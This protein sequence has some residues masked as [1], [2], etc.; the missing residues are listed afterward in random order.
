MRHSLCKSIL[1]LVSSSEMLNRPC[2]SSN[3]GAELTIE[4]RHK[5]IWR[6]DPCVGY[7]SIR[8]DELLSMCPEGGGNAHFYLIPKYCIAHIWIQSLA[9]HPT[10]L[11]LCKKGSGAPVGTLHLRLEMTELLSNAELDVRVANSDIQQLSKMEAGST[12]ISALTDVSSQ[13]N[14]ESDLYKTI[15]TLFSK[16]DVLVGFIDDVS[17]VSFI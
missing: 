5:S 13:F 8:L 1:D 2:S 10:P 11:F 7:A 14:I 4:L 16:L 17:K 12:T 3:P 9:T 6:S 15:G